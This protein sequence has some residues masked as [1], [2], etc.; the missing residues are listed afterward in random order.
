MQWRKYDRAFT[1][2]GGGIFFCRRV[3]DR[4]VLLEMEMRGVLFG[5]VS[6]VE[7]QQDMFS[8]P[9]P[10]QHVNGNHGT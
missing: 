7:A 9:S 5:D 1:A 4:L 10:G 3:R 6:A 8:E 2:R